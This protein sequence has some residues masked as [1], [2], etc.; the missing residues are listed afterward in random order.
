MVGDGDITSFRCDL[1]MDDN[2]LRLRFR[3]LLYLCV[4]QGV[5]FLKGRKED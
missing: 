2:C 5:T 3:L 4:D 1:W